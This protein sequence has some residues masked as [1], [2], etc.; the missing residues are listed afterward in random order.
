[1]LNMQALQAAE[2]SRSPFPYLVVPGFIPAPVLAELERDFPAIDKPGSFPLATLKY[3]PAFEAF[4]E[5]IRKAP[6]REVI[7]SKLGIDLKRRPT[8]ITVRGICRERDGQIHTDSKTKLV[9]VLIYMNGKW[10]NPGGRLRLLRTPDNLNDIVA[11]VPPEQ[12]TLLA[13]L[14][15]PNAW[16]GHESFS[17]PRR[18][19]QLNWVRDQGV[20]WREQLRHKVSAFFKKTSY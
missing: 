4:M 2:V 7:S 1:M 14:N 3:G 6:F 10:E 9:T 11:E 15:T 19:I 20:V 13:F 12:G 17:G 5:E 8:M 18:A 16:H